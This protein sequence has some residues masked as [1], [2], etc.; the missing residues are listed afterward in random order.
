MQTESFGA[1]L[2]LER[3]RHGIA[4]AAVSEQTKI[5]LALLEGLERDDL[6]HWPEGIF[7]RAYVRAYAKAVGRDADTTLREFLEVYPEPI[8]AAPAGQTQGSA[9][10]LRFLLD[11]AIGA[12]PG[13]R[14]RDERG[15]E[16]SANVTGVVAVAAMVPAVPA[17]AADRDAPVEHE[18]A[19]LERDVSAVARLCTRL[20]RA[21]ELADVATALEE[22]AGIL[23]AVGM[24]L[25][26]S[27]P[28]AAALTAVLGYGYADTM[29]AQLPR[30][31][32]GAD[33][34]IASVFR[35]AETRIVKGSD[36][37]TGAVAV[38]LMTPA[39]C[40]GVLAIELLHG[41]EQREAVR[42][43]ATILGAQLATLVVWP[44]VAEAVN[45]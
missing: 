10:R 1:R 26:I 30:V 29:L 16:I 32:R 2:R 34:A 20:A 28:Q 38:P 6:S 40:A 44:A 15:E 22:A 21:L 8:E 4:L 7:R 24:I 23:D 5:K 18:S 12:L 35:S 9:T 11:S 17:P 45:A 25:W 37:A 27:D 13:R 36:A 31:P 19:N 43:L 42:A 3:E 41:G 39:G 33:N 14:R